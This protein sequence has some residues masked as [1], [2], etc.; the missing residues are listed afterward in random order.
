MRFQEQTERAIWLLS[1]AG[2]HPR[3][4]V[5]DF[6]S[7][8]SVCEKQSLSILEEAGTP[9]KLRKNRLARTPRAT[10]AVVSKYRSMI[11]EQT[12]CF[13]GRTLPCPS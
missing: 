4:H 6:T 2:D 11:L 9:E 3:S 7:L 5:F 10:A 12:T 8:P 13:C 1:G